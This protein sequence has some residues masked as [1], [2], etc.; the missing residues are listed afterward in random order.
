LSTSDLSTWRG[1]ARNLLYYIGTQ[2]FN[3]VL[4][5]ASARGLSGIRAAHHLPRRGPGG[6]C[7]PLVQLCA[8]GQLLEPPRPVGLPKVRGA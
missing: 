7:T 8:V 2:G 5:A 6:T 4:G 3:A 1:R